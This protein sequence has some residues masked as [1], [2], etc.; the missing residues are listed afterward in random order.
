MTFFLVCIFFFSSLSVHDSFHMTIWSEFRVNDSY[1]GIRLKIQNLN[2]LSHWRWQ[3][4]CTDKWTWC[5]IITDLN[6]NFTTWKIVNFGKFD[7][8]VE[9]FKHPNRR[10]FLAPERKLVLVFL[11]AILFEFKIWTSN[12]PFYID[13][14]IVFIFYR[15]FKLELSVFIAVWTVVFYSFVAHLQ[16]MCMCLSL[17]FGIMCILCFRNISCYKIDVDALKRKLE[18]SWCTLYSMHTQ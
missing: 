11:R 13:K 5:A 3:W 10:L 8:L 15:V 16:C 17:C 14:K 9:N 18:W 7:F 4:H 6:T 1:D 12:D 2:Y